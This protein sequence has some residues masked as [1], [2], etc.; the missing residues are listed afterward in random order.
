MQPLFIEWASILFLIIVIVGAGDYDDGDYDDAPLNSHIRVNCVNAF[1]HYMRLFL[2]LELIGVDHLSHFIGKRSHH[3]LL[4]HAMHPLSISR[5]LLAQL[6]AD[7]WPPLPLLVGT[8]QLWSCHCHMPYVSQQNK[9]E[10]PML[11]W[12]WHISLC[13]NSWTICRLKINVCDCFA[14][15]CSQC[16]LFAVKFSMFSV[17]RSR[18]CGMFCAM[19]WWLTLTDRKGTTLRVTKE[20]T[21]WCLTIH[22]GETLHRQKHHETL[23]SLRGLATPLALALA[24]VKITKAF[25]RNHQPSP[26]SIKVYILPDSTASLQNSGQQW[27]NMCFNFFMTEQNKNINIPR[28]DAYRHW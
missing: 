17:Q 9:I 18:R 23:Q 2:N 28:Y 13:F 6:G 25:E 8:R 22:K 5:S 12:P 16:S 19:L 10:I 14:V 11:G 3:I 7:Q 4:M 24:T 1:L 21:L 27:Q 20:K 15:Y 26:S